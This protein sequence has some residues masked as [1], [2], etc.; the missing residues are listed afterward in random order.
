MRIREYRGQI[1]QN[2]TECSTNIKCGKTKK[3]WLRDIQDR[4]RWPNV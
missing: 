1:E 2:Y 3:G 4:R